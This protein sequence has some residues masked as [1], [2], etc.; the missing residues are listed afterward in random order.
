MADKIWEF[1]NKEEEVKTVYEYLSEYASKLND[2]TRG[3][4]K[5]TVTELISDS[6]EEVVYALYIVVPELRNYSYRLIEV[7]QNN[8][9]T[10]FPVKMRLFGNAAGN[11]EEK[12][13]VSS[14]N[15]ESE[16]IGFIQ[17]P[18]TKL[19]LRN[20]KTHIEIKRD[21]QE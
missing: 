18:L 9:F 16:L 4:F 13:D 15:F 14:R 2:D 8:A 21:Y 11:I 5:G 3:L 7:V 10:P 19:I 20:L 6:K 1:S 17:S 12:S